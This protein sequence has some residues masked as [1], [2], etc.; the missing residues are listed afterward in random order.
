MV[1][2]LAST[3]GMDHN[4]VTCRVRIGWRSRDPGAIPDEDGAEQ[5]RRQQEASHGS[6]VTWPTVFPNAQP[7]W[8]EDG[9][10]SL[11]GCRR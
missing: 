10:G 3:S 2:P 6:I 4:D 9:R 11:A 7:I 8:P 1:E 5:E